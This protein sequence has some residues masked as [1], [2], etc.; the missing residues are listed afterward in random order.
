M[1]LA[2]VPWADAWTAP[3]KVATVERRAR[4]LLAAFADCAAA[5]LAGLCEDARKTKDLKRDGAPSVAAAKVYNELDA[6]AG[7]YAAPGERFDVLLDPPKRGCAHMWRIPDLSER[8]LCT[9]DL[10]D[11]LAPGAVIPLDGPSGR[12]RLRCCALRPGALAVQ[13]VAVSPGDGHR[14]DALTI[15]VH[16]AEDGIPPDLSSI[17]AVCRD[18]QPDPAAGQRVPCT[19]RALLEHEFF[20]PLS[21][22]DLAA[23]MDS[24][25][26]L[27]LNEEDDDGALPY[28]AELPPA[29]RGGRRCDEPGDSD[30]S[31]GD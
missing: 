25:A 24:Y 22:E 5:I 23:A 9:V 7:V 15:P 17:L 31:R 11:G 18:D 6:V 4:R 1:R 8:Q 3:L 19:P 21:T 13:V 26:R 2:G 30:E 12:A 14:S 29:R 10:V 20:A 16:V 28:P 27:F